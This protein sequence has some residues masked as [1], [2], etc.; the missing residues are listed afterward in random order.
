MI[1]IRGAEAKDAA[2]IA[3]IYMPYVTASAISFES[4]PPDAEAIKARM[5]KYDGL[6]PWLVATSEDDNAVTGYAYAA[7][8]R[9]RPAYRYIVETSIYLGGGV[10]GAGVGRLL[11]NALIETLTAQHFTQAIAV[12]ALP[13]E[14]SIA[15]HEAVGFK[16]AGIYREIGWKNGQWHDVGMWQ[17]ELSDPASP[18]R[19][20]RHFSEV[21]LVRVG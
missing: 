3:A 19:T 2:Q 16:R 11:Y 9:D 5:T 4:E 6:Y 13:N 21:G 7:L 14:A 15:L 10:G 20:P 17:R 12:L 1:K 18:P 8:F